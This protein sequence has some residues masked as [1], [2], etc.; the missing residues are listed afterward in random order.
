MGFVVTI[1]IITNAD[2]TS[3]EIVKKNNKPQCML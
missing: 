3:K 2:Y 1:L